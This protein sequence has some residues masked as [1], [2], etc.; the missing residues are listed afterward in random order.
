MTRRRRPGTSDGGDND[1][2]GRCRSS[3]SALGIDEGAASASGEHAKWSGG[4]ASTIGDE[5]A[6]TEIDEEDKGTNW[7]DG[8]E[9]EKAGAFYTPGTCCPGSIHGPG[10]KVL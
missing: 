8:E 9:E 6:A 1:A 7:I 3:A 10:Q 4:G 2:A 5:R